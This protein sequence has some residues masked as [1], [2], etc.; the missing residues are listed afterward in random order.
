M[1]VKPYKI[2]YPFKKLSLDLIKKISQELQDGSTIR[3][4]CLANGITK[5][6]FEI[7]RAQ[8]QVDLEHDNFNSLPALLVRSLAN[9]HQNEVKKHCKNIAKDKRGHR[10]SEFLL[11]RKFWE[12]FT[13]NVATLKLNQKMD[14][15]LI[16]KYRSITD[17]EGITNSTEESFEKRYANEG[18]NE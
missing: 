13:P 1:D 18:K 5:R 17:G 15:L 12:D 6:I 4:A 11:E 2:P 8:G 10:G 16:D 9:V 7:W 14:D 3:L